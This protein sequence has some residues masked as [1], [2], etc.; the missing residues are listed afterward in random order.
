M[1]HCRVTLTVLTVLVPL[2]F[3]A[4]VAYPQTGDGI[5]TEAG[6]GPAPPGPFIEGPEDA[7]K[8]L[9]ASA[10]YP[11]LGQLLNDAEPKA[12]VLGAVEAALIAGLVV[13]DRRARNSLRMYEQTGESGYYDDYSEHFDRRQ[14]LVWWA[15]VAVVYGLT[16][17]YVDAHLSGF[18]ASGA[19]GAG[20]PDPLAFDGRE[21]GELRLGL[22]FRF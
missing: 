4:A 8:A 20:D 3:V 2:L 5:P 6:A 17:A 18:D 14:A 13:E 12:A 1:S 22:A 19:A 10:A 11:G 7:S 9:A 15:I 21:A 16:D